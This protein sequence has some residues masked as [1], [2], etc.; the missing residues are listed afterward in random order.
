VAPALEK[1]IPMFYF[2]KYGTPLKKAQ[3]KDASRRNH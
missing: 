3:K 1:K 2:D